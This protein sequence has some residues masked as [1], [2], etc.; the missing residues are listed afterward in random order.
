MKINNQKLIQPNQLCENTM[1]QEKIEKLVK[2]LS[3]DFKVCKEINAYNGKDF[4]RVLYK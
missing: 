4:K 1:D 2:I 3:K